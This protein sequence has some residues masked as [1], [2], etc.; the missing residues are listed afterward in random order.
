MVAR[1]IV[2]L[3]R[4]LLRS[5]QKINKNNADMSNKNFVRNIFTVNL[6]FSQNKSIAEI[7]MRYLKVGVTTPLDGDSFKD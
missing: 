5:S 4:I 6:R 2:L 7:L 3:E 1:Y